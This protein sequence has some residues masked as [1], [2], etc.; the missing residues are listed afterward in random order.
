[1][2]LGIGLVITTPV[3]VSGVFEANKY[4]QEYLY[5][6]DNIPIVVGDYE[7]ATTQD[8]NNLIFEDN[9]NCIF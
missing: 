8:D 2:K 1:M 3:S 6:A 9:I 5:P 4:L 7:H